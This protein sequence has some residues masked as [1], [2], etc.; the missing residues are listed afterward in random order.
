MLANERDQEFFQFLSERDIG[1]PVLVI[2]DAA[3]TLRSRHR[4]SAGEVHYFPKP[5]T[6]TDVLS[7]IDNL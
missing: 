1:I 6:S 3:D 5:Y 7:C 4:T 2:G